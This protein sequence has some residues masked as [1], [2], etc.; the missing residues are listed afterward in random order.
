MCNVM[1]F[2]LVNWSPIQQSMQDATEFFE[3]LCEQLHC[4]CTLGPPRPPTMVAPKCLLQ[5]NYVAHNVIGLQVENHM[6]CKHCHNKSRVAV[7]NVWSHIAVATC[8][9]ETEGRFE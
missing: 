8:I 4:A 6:L 3:L 7:H 2:R 5:D 1:I 9:R